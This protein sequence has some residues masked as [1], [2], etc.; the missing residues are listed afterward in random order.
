MNTEKYKSGHSQQFGY[1][2]DL[3]GGWRKPCFLQIIFLNPLSTGA[4]SYIPPGSLLFKCQDFLRQIVWKTSLREATYETWNN[5]L[6]SKQESC[7][8]LPPAQVPGLHWFSSV[9][10]SASTFL[11]PVMVCCREN[12]QRWLQG[13]ART[14]PCQKYAAGTQ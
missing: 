7:L 12:L 6:R 10:S 9:C 13:T 2:A 14:V 4:W 11:R 1:G 8:S 5:H 3:L